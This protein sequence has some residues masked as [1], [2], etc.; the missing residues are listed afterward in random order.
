MEQE[1]KELLES[2]SD[3][4]PDFVKGIMLSTR[5]DKVKQGQMCDFI[6]TNSEAKTDD[7][8]NYIDKLE[9]LI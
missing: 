8:I 2:V 6:K 9:G 7:I 5:G 4:Y 1:L 3:T